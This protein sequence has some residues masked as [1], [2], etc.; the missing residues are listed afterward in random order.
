MCRLLHI[1]L[2]LLLTATANA[3]NPDCPSNT[4]YTRGSAFE[5]NLDALL[6]FLPDAAA[7][8]S[9]F[10]E[11]V[12]G[13]APD[14]AYGLSQC[15]ADV[16]AQS[17]FACLD[18]SAQDIVSKCPGQRSAMVFDDECLLRHS[19]ASF[20][21]TVDTSLVKYWWNT[22]NATEP[23]RFTATLDALM[24]NVTA[25]AAYASQQMF[26]ASMVPFTPFVNIYGMAQCTRDL[27]PDGCNRCLATAVEAIPI[28]CDGKRG[29]QV[30]YRSCSIRFEV[31]SFYNATAVEAA[32]SPAPSPGGAPINGSDH[33]VPGNT[34]Q[35]RS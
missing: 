4:N 18:G 24:G 29:G 25:R 33:F 13:A 22:R 9:G 2:L 30:I 6:S 34:G 16:D 23:A 10:A 35:S 8:S 20:F 14:K 32:M 28:C 12:T 15:R 3:D 31:Y 27:A 17:C 21:G 19:N 26:A 7:K 5:A 11:N 1:L